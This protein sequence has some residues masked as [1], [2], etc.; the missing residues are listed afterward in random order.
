MADT[1]QDK[2]GKE[3]TT[4]SGIPLNAVY[5]PEDLKDGDCLKKLGNPGQFPYTRGVYPEMY[6]KF[7]WAIR[8]T[9]GYGSGEATA[10]R[11]K[12]L[13]ETGGQ[14]GYGGDPVNSIVFDGPTCWGYDSDSPRAAYQVGKVGLPIDH[15]EDFLP[16]LEGYPLD[17]GFTNLVIFNPSVP[18][19]AMY[20]AAAKKLGYSV[21]SLRGSGN[22]D[23]FRTHICLRVRLLKLTGQLRLCIDLLDYGIKNMPNWSSIAVSGF[24]YQPSGMNA[25]QSMA[26]AL[27]SG[28]AYIEAAADRGIPINDVARQITFFI[29][30]GV[31]FLEGIAKFRAARRLWATTLRDRFG[32]TDNKG[33]QFRIYGYTLTTDYTAQQPL[34]NIIRG[35][36]QGMACV[37]GGVQALNISPYDEALGI[38]TTE[39]QTM[40]IRAQQVIAEETSIPK[41]VDPFGGSYLI[42]YLTDEMESRMN[43]FMDEIKQLGDGDSFLKG[44]HTGMESRY[45]DEL[46][47]RMNWDR[48]QKIDNGEKTVVG[49][50]KYAS[51]DEVAPRAF[52][53][54]AELSRA[55]IEELKTYKQQRD[56]QKVE[57]AINKLR[58][59]AEGDENVMPAAIEAA[60]SGV[61]LEE[62]HRVFQE[63]YG[64]FD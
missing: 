19:M 51:E 46:I 13:L 3:H 4:S 47:E 43:G 12:D 15:Y 34:V 64:A 55:K 36:I 11:G 2:R 21:S 33:L 60:E 32:V 22:N 62:M 14:I 53:V 30:C 48:Q 35:T 63:V 42:E 45:F 29:G 16:L 59:V 18:L 50:N 6:R 41:V 26:M 9:M 31:D 7:P 61:T 8:Q 28:F 56:K 10:Q 39:A 5:T 1:P 37:L 20:I 57:Q 54:P 44:L 17:K 24:S 23:Y 58:K 38:P 25:W 49:L 40:S 27:A 52:K